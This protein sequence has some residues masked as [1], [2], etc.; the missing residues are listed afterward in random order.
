M[1][2]ANKQTPAART[3]AADAPPT[4]RR[5][6]SVHRAVKEALNGNADR[7]HEL[8]KRGKGPFDLAYREV[9]DAYDAIDPGYTG[10]EVQRR[11]TDKVLN[12]LFEAMT[13]MRAMV[14]DAERSAD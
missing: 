4:A 8:L 12:H 3:P 10:D 14:I 13:Y 1:S 9:S 2:R 7:L 5:R 11:L 6:A